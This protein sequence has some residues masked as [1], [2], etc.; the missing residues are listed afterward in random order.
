MPAG[1]IAL[2]G[3]VSLLFG[4]A[5]AATGVTAFAIG[6]ATQTAIG[7]ALYAL[8][9]KPKLG[10]SGAGGYLVTGSGS[11]LSHQVV[12]GKAKVAGVR[13][14]DT[15]AGNNGNNKFLHRVIAFAGHEIEAFEEI[16]INE[17][18]VASFD[19]TSDDGFGEGNV[20]TIEN[21]DAGG[22]PPEDASIY[23]GYIEVY[24]HYGTEDQEVDSLLRTRV[25]DDVNAPDWGTNHRLRGI[26][27]LYIRMKFDQEVFPDGIP[28]ITATIKGKKVFDPR[29][30]SAAPVW[31]DNPA[32][33]LRDYLTNSSYGLGEPDAN[34][35]D[36]FV[37]TAA[38]RC[39]ETPTVI[40][41]DDSTIGGDFFSCNGAFTTD[42]PPIDVIEGLLSS[43]AGLCW[44]SQNKWKIKAADYTAPTLTLDESN[45]IGPITVS[46]RHSR[47]DNFN[48]VRGTFRGPNTNW[49][50]TDFPPVENTDFVT[51]DNGQESWVDIPLPFT[52]NSSAARRIGRIVLEQNRQQLSV[53]GTFNLEAFQLQVGDVVGITNSRF[54][55]TAKEFEV[56]SWSFGVGDDLTLPITMTLR[57]TA[58]SVYDEVDDGIVYEQDN[59]TLTSPFTVETPSLQTPVVSNRL[60]ADGSS[61]EEILYTWTVDI[62]E[63]IAYYEFEW[64]LSADSNYNVQIVNGLQYLVSP[65]ANNTSYDARVRAVNHLGV[66]SAYSAAVGTS[67]GKD[68]TI[69]NEPSNLALSPG[70]GSVLVT[71]DAPTLNEDGSAADDIKDYAVY[72]DTSIIGSPSNLV[73][74]VSSTAYG[75]TGLND[76]T[77]YWYSI[78]SRDY[79][80]NLS[81]NFV[82][83]NATTL[84]AP[85]GEDGA[86]GSDAPR[87]PAR[88]DVLVD[89]FPG[90]NA[91]STLDDYYT[92]VSGYDEA[93]VG[94]QL[95]L[96]TEV[97][98]GVLSEQRVWRFE[99]RGQESGGPVTG[100]GDWIYQDFVFDGSLVVSESITADKVNIDG[101]T[102]DTFLNPVTGLYELGVSNDGGI[103]FDSLADNSATD[104]S[105]FRSARSVIKEGENSITTTFNMEHQGTVVATIV[106]AV[107][108]GWSSGDSIEFN[109]TI[110]GIRFPAWTAPGDN[111]AGTHTFVVEQELP[112]GSYNVGLRFNADGTNSSSEAV[113]D[114]VAIERFR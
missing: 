16:W 89:S 15:T 63:D 49:Q 10:A 90:N 83:G 60:Q 47:R 39:E 102:L 8:S 59:T 98:A 85:A 12:Y 110:N 1:T 46:T 48:G 84:V 45:L 55:W 71:W 94:D 35:D 77:E 64:K 76:N 74:Y 92:T 24:K 5:T 13:V 56:T 42:L 88:Y 50:V 2:G 14:F 6:L 80:G 72:R 33:C 23:D 66:K 79:S 107:F 75:D 82:Q 73:G 18:R 105:S 21:P 101:S 96:Y 51:A 7:L 70:Y 113:V 38:N 97:S 9:P 41:A 61:V 109:P 69:P 17:Y 3:S 81:S 22:D 95:W 19:D 25:G 57:E 111:I 62:P 103:T 43:M 28:E 44:Y 29:R 36:T 112:A 52:H 86:D 20:A 114:I 67:T 11:N 40:E 26:A 4:A 106:I 104:V 30:G 37:T 108:G 78:Y 31:S 68:N 34:I 99:L 32:L 58:A 100:T 65:A 87:T 93:I 27:Y 91:Q 54:G 53:E